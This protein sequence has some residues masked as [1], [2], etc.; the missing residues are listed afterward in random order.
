MTTTRTEASPRVDR[1]WWFGLAAVAA[2]AFAW[3][4]VYILV[5]RRDH[6]VWGD[7]YF[8]H[9]G[10]NLLADGYGFV[11][12]FRFLIDGLI[13]QAADHPPV[14]TVYLFLFSTLGVRSPTGHM[15]ATA[16][17]GTA[18]VV[19]AGLIG[20]RIAG[21]TT[22][23]VA[24]VLVAFY[25]NTFSWDGM[26][27]SE[28]MALFAV[29]LTAFLAY[30]FVDDP[31]LVRIVL[32]GAAV[33]LATLS[34]AELGLLAV[35]IV[36]P[37]VLRRSNLTSWRSRI[38]WLAASGAA[39]LAV[40]APWVAF[41]ATRFDEPVY[42]SSGF[43]ITLATVSCDKTYYGEL[44]GYWSLECVFGYLE[45]T[46]LNPLNSDE[47]QRGQVLRDESI[48]YIQEN[49]DRLPTVIVARW[50]RALGLWNFEQSV[51]LD[52]FDA[53]RTL[54]VAWA[55]A[56]SFLVM[57]PLAVVGGLAL[58]RRGKLVYPLAAPF[59]TVWFTATVTFGQPRYRALAE[60][61]LAV[62]A[63]VGLVA[64]VA[65]IRRRTAGG[66]ATPDGD[67]PPPP[68]APPLSGATVGAGPDP[69]P[70]TSDHV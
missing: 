1:R 42:L 28:P 8:Y 36:V 21:N 3:R 10:A 46:G 24:A 37:L 45:P 64:I 54:W 5:W 16:L 33:G 51:Q 48:D 43:E 9:H 12:P 39:C 15:L 65:A 40:L 2:A 18:S 27:L 59:L 63:A 52:S 67:A 58:R 56:V 66:D 30:R 50:G 25:P 34:R 20:R 62:L 4:A 60:G 31:S 38:G 13:Q 14:Y 57:A 47:S 11:N 55:G 53:G 44:T 29:M 70:E 49:L 26:L 6:Q 19:L 32:L 69:S 68:A 61:P 23:I 35:F 7:A 17:V 41:N 22:G